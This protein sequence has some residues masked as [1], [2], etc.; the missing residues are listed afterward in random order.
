M[1][2]LLDNIFWSCLSGPHARFATGTGSVRR[3]APGFSPIIG[4]E[5]SANP[6]FAALEPLCPPGE[7]IYIDVWSAPAPRGWEIEK[8]ARMFKMIWDGPPPNEDAAPDA[9]LL[10]PE[11]AAQAVELT[12]LTNPGPFGIRTPELGDYF[13]YFEDGRL[14][15]M[16]GERTEAQ[17]LREVSGI[18]THP[19]FQGR[20]LA[21]KLTLKLVHRHLQRGLRTYLHVMGHNTG[22]RRL[23][24]KMGFRDYLETT[25]RVIRRV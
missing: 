23:Y 1:I 12:R 3:Y 25:V 4:A 2:S 15:A 10:K 19:E 20:G 16:A 11:H 9:V 6:D 22:A 24:A 21:R 18:C 14:I 8:E 17:G 5:D 13:G 7:P